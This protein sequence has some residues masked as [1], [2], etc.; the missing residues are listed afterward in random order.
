M[1]DPEDDQR[2]YICIRSRNKR[3]LSAYRR[4]CKEG[5]VFDPRK[6][7]CAE[8][9]EHPSTEEASD[10]DSDTSEEL[11]E[12]KEFNCK[13]DGTFPDPKDTRRYYLC[14]KQCNDS[15]RKKRFTCANGKTFSPSSLACVQKEN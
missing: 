12:N 10:S 2:Y 4:S 8:S 11:N 1:A 7:R 14:E 9:I 13:T 6:Q 15:F 5:L 3:R